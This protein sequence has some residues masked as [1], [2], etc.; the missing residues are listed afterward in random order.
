M[1][2]LHGHIASARD[3]EKSIRILQILK[4][5]KRPGMEIPHALDDSVWGGHA[6]ALANSLEQKWIAKL[7]LQVVNRDTRTVMGT[8]YAD[9][10]DI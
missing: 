3:A 8:S 10:F 5:G 2:R 9:L 7:G 6:R 1:T 4:G